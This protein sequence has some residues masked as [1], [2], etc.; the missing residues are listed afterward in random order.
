VITWEQLSTLPP[1]RDATGTIVLEE[2][3]DDTRTATFRVYGR[4]SLTVTLTWDGVHFDGEAPPRLRAALAPPA[5]GRF[6]AA[7]SLR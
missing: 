4:T 2:A 7:G 6:V 5:F 1:L 3:D